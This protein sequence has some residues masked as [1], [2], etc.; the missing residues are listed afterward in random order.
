[1]N[2]YEITIKIT[3]SSLEEA[4]TAYHVGLQSLW[5][6]GIDPE[7]T[8]SECKLNGVDF[9]T[10]NG[11]GQRLTIDDLAFGVGEGYV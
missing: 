7:A 8:E 9:F 4:I 3:A 2:K 6:N 10:V 11:H 1:M 5:L